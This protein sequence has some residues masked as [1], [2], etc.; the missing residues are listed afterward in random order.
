MAVAKLITAVVLAD[1]CW[2]LPSSLPADHGI[3]RGRRVEK[4][5][6]FSQLNNAC[7]PH[8]KRLIM[9]YFHSPSSCLKLRGS[10][11][12]EIVEEVVGE[13]DGNVLDLEQNEE[14]QPVPPTPEEYF[15]FHNN[16]ALQLIRAPERE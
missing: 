12:A 2:S 15:E 5:F 8:S 11:D 1:C 16:A 6:E 4:N 7:S 13:Q 3:G 10:G 9:T 14:E